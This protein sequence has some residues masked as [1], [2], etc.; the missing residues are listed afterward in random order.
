LI[1]GTGADAADRLAVSDN[2]STLV[3]DS[4]ASVGLSYQPNYAAGKNKIINGDFGIWQRGTSFSDPA[5]GTYFADRFRTSYDGTAP[6]TRT[7]SQ[8]TFTLGTAPVAGYE[9]RFFARLAMTTKGSNTNSGFAHFIEDVRTFAGQTVTVSFYAKCDTARTGLITI[10]QQFGTG[11][12][13]SSFVS[14]ANTSVSYTSSWARYTLTIA[15][16]SISGKTIG[17]NNDS[18][19]E[20]TLLHTSADGSTFDIWGV[21][22]EAGSVATAFQTATGTLQG[23]LAAC[24][25]YYYRNN[26]GTTYGAFSLGQVVASDQA[27]M[28]I[29]YPVQMRINPSSLDYSNVGATNNTH[30][31]VTAPS[32]LTIQHN[33]NLTALLAF[34]ATGA[35]NAAGDATTFV[36]N[37]STAGYIAFNAEL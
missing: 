12:S 21:Q 22:V 18:R 33:G 3:A 37:N 25:R 30:G 28:V 16:P 26:P 36:A 10:V 31:A 19:L 29:N 2:G 24:Q 17:T 35:F 34:V 27:R 6:T 5:G 9:G 1:V 20:I 32:S 7:Y 13:P 8:E 14:V 15:I 11:G 4:A 23:E